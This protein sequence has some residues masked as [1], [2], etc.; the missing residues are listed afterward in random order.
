MNEVELQFATRCVCL[1][2]SSSTLPPNNAQTTH[3]NNT[4]VVI[5]N[6]QD[7]PHAS[8]PK[9]LRKSLDLDS[10]EKTNAI[11]GATA[12]DPEDTGIKDALDWLGKNMNPI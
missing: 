6:K 11:F 1:F 9:E 4:V 12:T 8:K 5:A 3:Q 10:I 7:L 2:P